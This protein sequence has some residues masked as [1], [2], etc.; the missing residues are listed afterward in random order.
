ME[1][2]TLRQELSAACRSFAWDQWA[3]MG[4]LASSPR[5]D[6]WAMDPE[7][8][9]VF[10]LRAARD[11]PRL[12]EELLDW[13]H[14]NER[15]VS[16]QR[17]RNLVR[18]DEPL[19]DAALS[20]VASWKRRGRRARESPVSD[21]TSA[22]TPLY[23]G[24]RPPGS[25][26]DEAFAA[27]GY[28][29]SPT[30]PSGKSQPPPADLPINL[31]FRLRLLF[32]V[33]VRAEVMRC[34]LTADAPRVTVQVIA[35]SAVYSRRNVQEALNSLR[36]ARVI[37]SVVVGPEQS[38]RA[39][40]SSWG[41]V[42]GLDGGDWPVQREWPQLL[43]S[44]AEILRWLENHEACELSDYMFE[45]HARDLMEDVSEALLYAGVPVYPIPS[46]VGRGALDAV[47]A[48]A[49]QAIASLG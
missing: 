3:Q 43:G 6:P 34:L 45:S 14:A 23:H 44:V 28:A 26:L 15:L 38:Y 5:R 18:G 20:R 13:M 8:L 25:V 33:S 36:A 40:Q 11:D 49:R 19:V 9:I 1:V 41:A 46:G 48:T 35:R 30:E 22:L 27:H 24:L 16:V 47:A 4:V 39:D 17:L 12:F 31:A 37:S 32:G 7:A 2:S 21:M 29:K 10:T 42:L